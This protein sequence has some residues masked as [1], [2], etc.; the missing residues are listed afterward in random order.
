M[1]L[2]RGSR[3]FGQRARAAPS[4]PPYTVLTTSREPSPRTRSFVKDLCTLSAK[5]LRLTRGKATYKELVAF[6]LGVGARTLAMVGEKRGNPSILRIYDL[7]PCLVGK[8]PVH[9]Y[10]LFIKG[11]NLSRE[12][13][14]GPPPSPCDRA[15][16]VS[17]GEREGTGYLVES[18]WTR[19]F[20]AE[21]V[22]REPP[23]GLAIRVERSGGLFLTHFAFNGRPV[24][25]LIKV[26]EARL[27]GK[28]L[29]ELKAA[30]SP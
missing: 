17:S 18:A 14:C 20:M 4:S 26:D 11:V 16:V 23:E 27:I 22:T 29:G 7:E 21:V 10:T 13:G 25:P 24:G 12:R 5:V 28:T 30:N 19:F 3:D 1:S 9:L 6:A 2:S 8:S 15:F